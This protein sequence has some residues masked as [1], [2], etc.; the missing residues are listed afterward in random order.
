MSGQTQERVGFEAWLG[1]KPCGA[2]HDLAYEAFKAGAAWQRAQGA[3]PEPVR[4]A[5][6]RRCLWLAFCWNDHNFGPAHEEARKEALKHGIDSFDAANEWLA[7]APAQPA[8]QG[9]FGDAY[10]G[11]REDL[12][13]WKRRALEAEAKVRHQDQIIDQMGEDLNAI[14]GPTFMGEPVLPASPAK[15]E[16]QRLREALEHCSEVMKDP[17][18]HGEGCISRAIYMADA[19]LA[20]STGQEVGK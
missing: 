5:L 3:V 15:P 17:W 9:E 16:A 12:A 11:A 18:K 6:A 7:A 1:I 10:Q 4:D 2:A 19:A 13:F 8:V 14:N 20:A